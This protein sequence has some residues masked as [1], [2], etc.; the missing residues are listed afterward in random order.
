MTVPFD[1]RGVFT[2]VANW[3]KIAQRYGLN[4]FEIGK[5]FTPIQIDF[6]LTMIQEENIYEKQQIDQEKKR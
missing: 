1:Q 2:R 6:V 4:P 3:D 5:S